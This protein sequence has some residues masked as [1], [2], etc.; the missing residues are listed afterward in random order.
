MQTNK[1]CCDWLQ[2]LQLLLYTSLWKLQLSGLLLVRLS[3]TKPNQTAPSGWE[4]SSSQHFWMSFWNMFITHYWQN[5]QADSQ[6]FSCSHTCSPF[7]HAEVSA[8][9]P[10]AFRALC[11]VPLPCKCLWAESQRAL[12]AQ[13]SGAQH[14]LQCSYRCVRIRAPAS[15]HRPSS[16][17]QGVTTDHQDGIYS[18]GSG[19]E[20]KGNS[21]DVELFCSDICKTKHFNFLCQN[22]TLFW[23]FK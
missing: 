14:V 3:A 18:I 21:Q 17:G 16:Q 5:T 13:I 6:C 11:I 15:S 12:P 2:R 22:E 1:R 8:H 10:T 4:T 20:K 9:P 23:L 19:L 7:D